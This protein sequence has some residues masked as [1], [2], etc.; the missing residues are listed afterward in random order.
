MLSRVIEPHFYTGIQVNTFWYRYQALGSSPSAAIV[1]ILFH[2]WVLITTFVSF[3]RIYY[4]LNIFR[5]TGFLALLAPEWL[6]PALPDFA[7]NLF[8]GDKLLYTGIYQYNAP[9]IPFVM[10]CFDHWPAT[11]RQTLGT[12]AGR[13]LGITVGQFLS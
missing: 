12:L 7:L 11:R 1:N 3:D 9:I 2:P 6:L 8:S 10:M 5:G 13:S 4:L